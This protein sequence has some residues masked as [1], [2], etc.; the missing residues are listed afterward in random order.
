MTIYV[1]IYIY[2]Y[3]RRRHYL[4]EGFQKK[5]G[6]K[7]GRGKKGFELQNARLQWV[8]TIWQCNCAWKNRVDLYFTK[9]YDVHRRV[10]TLLADDLLP[11]IT[12]YSEKTIYISYLHNFWSRKDINILRPDSESL[13]Y[14]LFKSIKYL[15]NSLN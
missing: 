9:I 4:D 6:R 5:K 1:Y 10:G 8:M 11:Q 7:D 13:S 12:I 15:S 3:T 2:I 14:V